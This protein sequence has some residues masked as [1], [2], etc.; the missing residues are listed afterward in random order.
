M[1]AADLP[2]VRYRLVAIGPSPT[3][4]KVEVVPPWLARRELLPAIEQPKLVIAPKGRW[5]IELVN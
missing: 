3:S 2:Q 4:S 1:V 5:E